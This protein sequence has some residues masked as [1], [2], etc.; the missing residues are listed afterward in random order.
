MSKGCRVQTKEQRGL[1]GREAGGWGE[2]NRISGMGVSAE[3]LIP[4]P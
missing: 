1:G 3:S 2:V 4:D